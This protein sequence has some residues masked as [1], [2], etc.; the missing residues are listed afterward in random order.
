M[1]NTHKF[2][3]KLITPHISKKTIKKNSKSFNKK[4]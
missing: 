3:N 2:N 1:N 4:L